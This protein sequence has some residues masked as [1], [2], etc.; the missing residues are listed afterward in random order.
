MVSRWVIL[1]IMVT[2]TPAGVRLSKRHKRGEP[3]LLVPVKM[4]PELRQRFRVMARVEDMTYARL[5]EFLMD[6]HDARLLRQRRQQA[7]PLHRPAIID[8]TEDA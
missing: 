6:E 4:T 5:I 7:H 1:V 8:P 2:A 3:T